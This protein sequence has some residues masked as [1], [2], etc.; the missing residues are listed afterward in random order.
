[1]VVPLAEE[2]ALRV[3]MVGLVEVGS[4]LPVELLHS[5]RVLPDCCFIDVGVLVPEMSLVISARGAAVPMSLPAITEVFSSAVFSGVSLLMQ[6]P[7]PPL[8]DVGTVT[9]RVAV[10]SDAGNELPADSDRAAAVR[11]APLDEAVES[12]LDV[13]GL[14]VGQSW[15]RTDSEDIFPLMVDEHIMLCK[16]DVST[17]VR[18]DDRFSPGVTGCVSLDR[19][20]DLDS[21]GEEHWERL[22]FGGNSSVACMSD[23]KGVLDCPIKMLIGDGSSMAHP[24]DILIRM[25][26]SDMVVTSGNPG[27]RSRSILHHRMSGMWSL[28]GLLSDSPEFPDTG[29]PNSSLRMS[30]SR[31]DFS[32]VG[33]NRGMDFSAQK[34]CS[35]TLMPGFGLQKFA[36]AEGFAD[37]EGFA[38]AD[39]W[40][41]IKPL[42]GGVSPFCVQPVNG[43]HLLG[44][45]IGRVLGLRQPHL[46]FRHLS[47][48]MLDD[49][50]FSCILFWWY[51]MWSGT[52]LPVVDQ[53]GA[54][55]AATNLLLGMFK[56]LGLDLKSDKLYD[57][58]VLF[59]T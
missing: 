20:S 1:M 9:A 45:P 19:Q 44:S 49:L 15:F 36:G 41:Y 10:L 59:W 46:P 21:H 33:L 5:E 6:P 31:D 56:V 35:R 12:A 53:A 55:T 39:D 42:A 38:G 34:M 17:D 47:W 58:D 13:V 27:L 57:L 48:A 7:P 2:V 54:A 32:N 29:D 8:A 28:F 14:N 22:F 25:N 16:L 52:N 11:A 40:S 18:G 43:S 51:T 23:W 50:R 24:A 37:A 4:D 30:S 3:R 26:I